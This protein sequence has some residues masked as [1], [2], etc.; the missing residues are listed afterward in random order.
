MPR[1]GERACSC[2]NVG[3]LEGID[4]EGSGFDAWGRVRKVLAAGGLSKFLDDHG[5]IQSASAKETLKWTTDPEKH[6]QWSLTRD[7]AGGQA[8]EK[9]YHLSGV[10][11]EN[12]GDSNQMAGHAEGNDSPQ[13]NI[14]AVA[15]AK[16][17]MA[18]ANKRDMQLSPPNS[19]IARS[20][21]RIRQRQYAA[22]QQILPGTR[23]DRRRWRSN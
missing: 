17:I 14:H 22:T 15:I 21:A 4:A 16:E 13:R 19:L 8:R 23:G 2:S 5:A 10:V 1:P 12:A 18:I 20:K 11:V 7:F 6:P 3:M 9:R